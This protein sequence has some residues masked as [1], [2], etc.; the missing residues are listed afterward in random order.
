MTG[1]RL[2]SV[3]HSQIITSMPMCYSPHHASDCYGTDG[4]PISR[5]RRRIVKPGSSMVFLVF[6]FARP[7]EVEDCNVKKK[8]WNGSAKKR[9]RSR[10]RHGWPK[11]PASGQRKQRQRSFRLPWLSFPELTKLDDKKIK[12]WFHLWLAADTTHHCLSQSLWTM[13]VDSD[14]IWFMGAKGEM[15]VTWRLKDDRAFAARHTFFVVPAR[16]QERVSSLMTWKRV[17]YLGESASCHAMMFCTWPVLYFKM[18]VILD[19]HR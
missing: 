18:N 11:A 19:P 5:K 15:V 14:A 12:M 2:A 9:I 10:P 17:Q 1:N 16:V 6:A 4:L 13:T 3:V 7:N 8:L